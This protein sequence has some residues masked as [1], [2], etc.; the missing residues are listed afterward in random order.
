MYYT[1]VSLEK[2]RWTLNGHLP[3]KVSED[4]K[5]KLHVKSNSFGEISSLDLN[6]TQYFWTGS[7]PILTTTKSVLPA[8]DTKSKIETLKY[9][10][11]LGVH[12]LHGK[13]K[14]VLVV[15]VFTYYGKYRLVFTLLNSD[16]KLIKET[17]CIP[18]STELAFSPVSNRITGNILS[19]IWN[20]TGC[21]EGVNN[22]HTVITDVDLGHWLSE[23]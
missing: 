19:T 13:T 4:I 20:K 6:G 15:S 16:L 2:G 7:S 10:R 5:E 14:R 11:L 21:L 9:R 18:K 12:V 3:L 8:F 17:Y 23:K 1:K 22:V